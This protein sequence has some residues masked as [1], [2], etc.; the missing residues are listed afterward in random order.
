MTESK[1]RRYA[2]F[3]R[4]NP[5]ADVDEELEFHLGMMAAKHVAAGMTA[6]AA[7]KRAVNDFGDLTRAR[8]TVMAIDENQLRASRRAELLGNLGLD[9]RHAVRRLMKSPTF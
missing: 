2:R 1:W 5:R 6:D 8:E 3:I 4:S 7:R 9:L